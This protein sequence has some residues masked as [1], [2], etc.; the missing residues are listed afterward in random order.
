MR[1]AEGVQ[2]RSLNTVAHRAKEGS[3][4]DS[5]ILDYYRHQLNL[6]SNMCLDRQYLAINA[7][8]SALDIDLILRCA[9][10]NTLFVLT[11]FWFIGID[12]SH[13][14]DTLSFNP[15]HQA[16]RLTFSGT[17]P[18]VENKQYIIASVTIPTKPAVV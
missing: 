14:N 10:T 8:S 18:V 11:F 13:L 16:M 4:E 9:T 7:L 15:Y 6:F 3:E 17:V 2:H 12:P 5:R 1:W